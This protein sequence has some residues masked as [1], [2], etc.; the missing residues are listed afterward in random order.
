MSSWP[1]KPRDTYR[2]GDVW[3]PLYNILL[4]PHLDI[5]LNFKSPLLQKR[6]IQTGR[7][8]RTTEKVNR[9]LGSVLL[10]KTK[11]KEGLGFFSLE[12]KKS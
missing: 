7:G 3:L 9:N 8:R 4:R 5:T 12:I 2:E 10:E 1:Y 11:K 6:L